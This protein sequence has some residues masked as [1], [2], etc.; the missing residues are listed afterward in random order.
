MTET[1]QL[2]NNT[3][4]GDDPVTVG[5]EVRTAPTTFRVRCH[6]VIESGA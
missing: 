3:I 2:G 4:G 6:H 1:F 5:I